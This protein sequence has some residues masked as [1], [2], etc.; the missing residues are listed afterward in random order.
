MSEYRVLQEISQKIYTAQGKV[1]KLQAVMDTLQPTEMVI[2]INENQKL[3][4]EMNHL[5]EEQQA[6]TQK[7]E[8]LQEKSYRVT[9]TL[10]TTQEIIK[11]VVDEGVE[12]MQAHVT[13]EIVEQILQKEQEVKEKVAT[14][15]AIFE[16]FVVHWKKA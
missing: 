12:K 16:A 11:H 8:V 6:R 5:R 14:M 3:Y 10:T 7:I 1:H 9:V 4:S 15:K 13:A 2:A